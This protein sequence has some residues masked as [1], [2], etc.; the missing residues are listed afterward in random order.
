[1][2]GWEVRESLYAKNIE[3]RGEVRGE[4]KRARADVLRILQKRLGSPVPEPIRLAIEGTNDL[5]LLDSWLDAALKA[6]SWE[7]FQAA[8]P[9]A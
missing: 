9:Q 7:D 2:E 4:V 6:A 3:V 5:A 1:L 8:L